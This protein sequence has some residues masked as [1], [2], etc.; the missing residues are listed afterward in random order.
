MLLRCL[1]HLLAIVMLLWSPTGCMSLPSFSKNDPPP[2]AQKD[3]KDDNKTTQNQ[4]G[5]DSGGE[6]KKE[7]E[8][9]GTGKK[10][11]QAV[12]DASKS[13]GQ[14]MPNAITGATDAAGKSL[15]CVGDGLKVADAYNKEGFSGAVQEGAVLTTKHAISSV[16]TPVATSI[17]TTVLTEVLAPVVIGGTISMGTG[18]VLVGIGTAVV[19]FGARYAVGKFV[20]NV[21]VPAAKAGADALGDAASHGFMDDIPN[22]DGMANGT[23]DINNLRPRV[24]VPTVIPTCISHG[25]H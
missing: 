7:T 10:I 3:D 25:G 6:F 4:S 21:V 14:F 23:P 18:L 9:L 1:V 24:T 22:V 2:P 12:T 16:V 17:A 8:T 19:G 20:D 13:A 15:K 11:F 5:G